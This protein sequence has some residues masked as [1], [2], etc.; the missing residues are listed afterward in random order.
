MII[1]LYVFIS[2]LVMLGMMLDSYGKGHEI[3]TETWFIWVLS[4]FTFP[5]IIGME[6]ADRKE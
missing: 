5:V 2:Y 6:I 3:P 4:P 1:L